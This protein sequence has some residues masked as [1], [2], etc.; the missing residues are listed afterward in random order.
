MISENSSE[1]IDGT[2]LE[3]PTGD[4]ILGP[5][6]LG[7]VGFVTVMALSQIGKRLEPRAATGPSNG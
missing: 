1:V 4:E 7:L 6:A 3:L 2:G 5:A